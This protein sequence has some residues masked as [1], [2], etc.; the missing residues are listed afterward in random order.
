M[1]VS[2]YFGFITGC[3]RLYQAIL[4]AIL[5]C[6]KA[7][8]VLLKDH[9]EAVFRAIWAVLSRIGGRFELFRPV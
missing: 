2:G 6:F 4:G 9:I 8:I 1:V 5:G 3:F 7:V